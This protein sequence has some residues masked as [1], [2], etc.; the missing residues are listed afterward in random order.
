MVFRFSQRQLFLLKQD[1][2]GNIPNTENSCIS[3]L[4]AMFCFPCIYGQMNSALVKQYQQ[5]QHVV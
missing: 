2:N 5:E 3:L 4:L 1:E